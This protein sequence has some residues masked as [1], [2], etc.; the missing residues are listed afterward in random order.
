MLWER[1]DFLITSD[2]NR[3]DIDALHAMLSRGRC[4][5]KRP[6]LIGSHF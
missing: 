5:L 2:T 4:N 3:V 6:S 1:G